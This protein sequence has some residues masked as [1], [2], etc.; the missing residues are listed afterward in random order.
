M[1]SGQKRKAP[2]GWSEASR[3]KLSASQRASWAKR[4]KFEP[5]PAA[6][7]IVIGRGKKKPAEDVNKI[8]L[9]LEGES[10]KALAKLTRKLDEEWGIGV[11]Y[12]QALRYVLRRWE[13][14]GRSA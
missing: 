10:A 1:S 8:N 3:K 5:T 14:Q 9:V 11:T 12:P 4:K 13:E 2:H 7:P 6:M